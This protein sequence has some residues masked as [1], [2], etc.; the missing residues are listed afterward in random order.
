[1]KAVFL[2]GNKRVELRAVEVPSPGPGE[3]LVQVKASCICRSDLSL[4][5]GNAVVGGEAAGKCVT[6]HEPAGIIAATGAG[7]KRFKAGD[8]VAVYLAVGC[9]VCA[10]CRMGNF[11][12]CPDWRCS[13]SPPTAATQ[14]IWS[15]LSAIASAS[16]T[17][18]RMSRRRSRPT[19][20]ARSTA[21]AGN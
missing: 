8:R 20:S 3:V 1:M 16:P 4:Y 2:P 10:A 5:Y 6:G 17:R 11:F 14:N 18:S 9:G 12:L 7:V 21:P 13:A 19:R 15:F